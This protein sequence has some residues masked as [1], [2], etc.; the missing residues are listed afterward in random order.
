MNKTRHGTELKQ[1][2]AHLHDSK[3]LLQVSWYHCRTG[4][5]HEVL[6]VQAPKATELWY[7]DAEPNSLLHLGLNAVLHFSQAVSGFGG[8]Q[9]FVGSRLLTERTTASFRQT[10]NECG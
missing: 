8:N 10:L 3:L 1:S 7:H 2:V 9:V 4:Q 5:D 6:S